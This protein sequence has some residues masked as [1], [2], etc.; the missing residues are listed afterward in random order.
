[1]VV[2]VGDGLG[3]V[4]QAELAEQVVDVGFH[5]GLGVMDSSPGVAPESKSF[6]PI[7]HDR[8]FEVSVTA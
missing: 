1:M 3:A 7:D 2:G 8:G 6:A 4:V 5:C